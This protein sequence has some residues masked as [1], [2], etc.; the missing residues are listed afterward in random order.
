VILFTLIQF[1]EIF[2]TTKKSGKSGSFFGSVGQYVGLPVETISY[3]VSAT[4]LYN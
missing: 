2:V 4:A 3:P 1:V